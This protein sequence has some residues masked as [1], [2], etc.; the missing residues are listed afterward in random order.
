M[1]RAAR[2]EQ[3]RKDK[4]RGG[5]NRERTERKGE[6]EKR[7]LVRPPAHESRLGSTPAARRQE[8]AVGRKEERN[9]REEEQRNVKEQPNWGTPVAQKRRKEGRKERDGKKRDETRMTAARWTSQVNRGSHSLSTAT[10][11]RSTQEKKKW[12]KGR[13]ETLPARSGRRDWSRHA[14]REGEGKEMD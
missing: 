13:D 5:K 14:S 11:P 2:T 9:S 3:T 6:S 4:R 10:A 1:A 12:R 8:T 7:W